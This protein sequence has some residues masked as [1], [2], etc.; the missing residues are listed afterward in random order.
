M[1]RQSNYEWIK[2][3]KGHFIKQDT[4]KPFL[5]CMRRYST[6][7]V[8]REI[9]NKS[10]MRKP[11]TSPRMANTENTNLPTGTAK[12]VE[13]SEIS[14]TSG[15]NVKWYSRSGKRSVSYKMKCT[16]TLLL[17]HSTL[18]HSLKRSE[19]ICPYQRLL[20]GHP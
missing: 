15:R 12:D 14:C 10:Q 20:Y 19:S 3:L 8:I 4:G 16:P 18:R 2:G 17:N 7:L 6:L 1:K 13:Y 11:C 9:K 5:G